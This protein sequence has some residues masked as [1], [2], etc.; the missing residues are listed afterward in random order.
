MGSIRPWG[1]VVAGIG[2][3]PLHPNPID[4]R[5]VN[6]LCVASGLRP[7]SSAQEVSARR[8]N[9]FQTQRRKIDVG[10]G[11]EIAVPETRQRPKNLQEFEG[12]QKR[13]ERV[14]D[15]LPSIQLLVTLR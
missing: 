2:T 13:R 4:S 1:R 11:P 7:D 9:G 15:T 12:S 6:H 10:P 14:F 5:G 8:R 3:S